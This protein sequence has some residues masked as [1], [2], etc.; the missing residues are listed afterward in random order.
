MKRR[1]TGLLL[2][3]AL[4]CTGCGASDTDRD[5]RPAFGLP[6]GQEYIMPVLLG[7]TVE[8]AE[9]ICEGRV[10]FQISKQHTAEDDEGEII[11]QS[12][13]PGTTVLVGTVV[14]LTVSEG[15]QKVPV[16]ALDGK[17]YASAADTL[18]R[19]KL[20]PEKIMV[21]DDTVKQGTVVRTDPKHGHRAAEGASVLVYVSAGPDAKMQE[22]P[23]L[24]GLTLKQAQEKAKEAGIELE[25]SYERAQAAD[26]TVIWQELR[27]G[28]LCAAGTVQRITVAG[29]PEDSQ[30]G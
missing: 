30:A 2:C 9:L 10:H 27:A 17:S 26:G 25:I 8:E 19:L 1:L 18:R 21:Q 12:V 5:V 6:T 23:A 13:K 24:V 15:R 16:P 11:A 22:L 4:L 28:L 3:A 14:E 20:R 7:D 29:V